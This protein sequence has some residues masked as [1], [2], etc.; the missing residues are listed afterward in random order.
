MGNS[1]RNLTLYGVIAIFCL[2]LV[3]T[4]A[5]VSLHKKTEKAAVQDDPE[6]CL[7]DT[8]C[9]SR[10]EAAVNQVYSESGYEGIYT[11]P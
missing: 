2:L 11:A 8:D 7:Q 9:R 3:G 1:K 10:L 5:V 6:K 4:V